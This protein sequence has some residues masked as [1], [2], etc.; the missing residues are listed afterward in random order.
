MD[1]RR[2]ST[3]TAQALRERRNQPRRGQFH[4]LKGERP[5]A[6]SRDAQ[7]FKPHDVNVS[8]GEA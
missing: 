6:P 7:T 3:T 8:V 1:T 4:S 2:R 5:Y